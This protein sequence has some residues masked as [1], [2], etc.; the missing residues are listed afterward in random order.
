MIQNRDRATRGKWDVGVPT[1]RQNQRNSHFPL[2]ESR[3]T[4]SWNPTQF[5]Y[6]WV[7]QSPFSPFLVPEFVKTSDFGFSRLFGT[8]WRFKYQPQQIKY[9]VKTKINDGLSKKSH[10][11]QE[12]GENPTSRVGLKVGPRAKNSHSKP[13]KA[14]KSHP[15][16]GIFKHPLCSDPRVALSL[17]ESESGLKI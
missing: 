3:G 13:Q 10:F 7:T 16:R 14:R 1:P 2:W 8:L 5:V 12:F 11:S 4:D 17:V 6:K 15:T 9:T